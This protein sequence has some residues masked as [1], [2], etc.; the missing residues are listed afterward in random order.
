MTFMDDGNIYTKVAKVSCYLCY[1][2]PNTFNRINRIIEEP[3]EINTGHM[4]LPS[5]Y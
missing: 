3:L 4:A 5:P 2:P 1:L